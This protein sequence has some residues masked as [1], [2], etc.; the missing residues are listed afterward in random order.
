MVNN[1]KIIVDLMVKRID[2]VTKFISILFIIALFTNY[3]HDYYYVNILD[4]QPLLPELIQLLLQKFE[5]FLYWIL[6][7]LYGILEIFFC[8][9]IVSGIVERV[10]YHLQK[11]YSV[12]LSGI[13]T[14][15]NFL[16]FQSYDLITIVTIFGIF[17]M[18]SIY[19]ILVTVNHVGT[20]I[21][22]DIYNPVLDM[23][24]PIKELLGFNILFI[25]AI[26]T[27]KEWIELSVEI[28][29]YIVIVL[30][31]YWAFIS[32]Y[33]RMCH[34]KRSCIIAGLL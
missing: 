32:P 19:Y 11:T 25:D 13:N 10:T 18:G 12:N 33:M 28:N 6:P 30:C 21:S 1:I 26:N 2:L 16:F 4:L 22:T 3:L 14:F 27:H 20:L 7:F 29:K 31:I 9:W 5:F 24:N 8:F 17:Y 34:K 15:S 23:I